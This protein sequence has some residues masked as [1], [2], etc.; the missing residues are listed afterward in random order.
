MT[1]VGLCM[2]V[3]ARANTIA[4]LRSR[5]RISIIALRLATG[6]ARLLIHQLLQFRLSI[7]VN[8]TIVE[9]IYVFIFF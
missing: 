6:V 3:S 8:S 7:S 2:R 9:H 5:S 4:S 1:K